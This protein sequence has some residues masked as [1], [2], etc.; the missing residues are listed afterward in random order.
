MIFE[1][2]IKHLASV[3]ELKKTRVRKEEALTVE[4]AKDILA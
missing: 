1:R 4:D 2:L 3:E